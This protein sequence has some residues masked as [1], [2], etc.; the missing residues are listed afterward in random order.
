MQNN[1]IDRR[2]TVPTSFRRD[3][4]LLTSGR[5]QLSIHCMYFSVVEDE[6]YDVLNYMLSIDPKSQTFA[7]VMTYVRRRMG[8]VS[9]VTKELVQKWTSSK[10]S[11]HS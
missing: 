5:A 8:G 4:L 10:H 3:G 7:T 2:R 1:R 6:F 11:L 9:L